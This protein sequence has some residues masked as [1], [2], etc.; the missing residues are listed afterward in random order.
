MSTQT[1][2]FK[3]PVVRGSGRGKK[4]EVPTLNFERTAAPQGLSDGIY[5]C[6]VN[7][8]GKI[9]PGVMHFGPRPV[10]QD[11]ASCEIHII[12]AAILNPPTH[13]EIEVIMK[14]RDVQDFP[15]PE[16][17]VEQMRTDIVDARAILSV[18]D[19]SLCNRSLPLRGGNCEGG[20]APRGVKGKAP[21]ASSTSRRRIPGGGDEPACR[22]AGRYMAGW[23]SV[24]PQ[25]VRGF[26]ATFCRRT[27]GGR[28][29]EFRTL[30]GVV[31]DY[32]L[33]IGQLKKLLS[34]RNPLRLSVHRL[35]ALKAAL[36]YGFPARKLTVIGITGTDGKTTT[37]GMVMHILRSQGIAAGAL[38][39]AFFQ[40]NDDV[41]WNPTQ[42][43]SPS[44]ST[45]QRFLR[46]LTQVYARSPRMFLARPPPGTN[47]LYLAERCRNHEY[48]S[49][50]SRLPR[51][52]GP[53]PQRQRNSLQDA[54]RS[55]N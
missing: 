53:V 2:H 46:T 12:D 55:R 20:C 19:S 27:K 48:I 8:E 30:K 6:F 32:L 38:S 47:A 18:S 25:F 34:H 23:R 15:G 51:H 43:T 44:P 11:S 7:V 37:V 39:T 50:T 26:G 9:F 36:Q 28:W 29:T 35:R 13:V 45:V 31:N 54:R 3:A 5:A 49:R 4:L 24:A 33:M 42:K 21:P 16:A 40:I 10:F 41:Q 22:Q 17:L 14:L 52:D 1:L